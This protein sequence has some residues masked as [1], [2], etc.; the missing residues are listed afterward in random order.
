MRHISDIRFSLTREPHFAT[1][2]LI[3]K[4]VW[5]WRYLIQKLFFQNHIEP[6]GVTWRFYSKWSCSTVLSKIVPIFNLNASLLKRKSCPLLMF[7]NSISSSHSTL[8]NPL[9]ILYIWIRSPHFI[10]Y[11]TWRENARSQWNKKDGSEQI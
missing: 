11:L 10:S 7:L 2:S 6:R 1:I 5:M 4:C 9:I 8:S 3:F